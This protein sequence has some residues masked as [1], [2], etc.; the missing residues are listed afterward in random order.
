MI[1]SFLRPWS[2]GPVFS[3]GD[4]GGGGKEDDNAAD[5]FARSARTQDRISTGQAAQAAKN[6]GKSIQELNKYEYTTSEPSPVYQD[7]I[8]RQAAQRDNRSPVFFGGNDDNET[9]T[10]ERRPVPTPTIRPN[11]YGATPP[12]IVGQDYTDT[13][14]Q[15]IAPNATVPYNYRSSAQFGA[16]QYVSEVLGNDS[17][18]YPEVPSYFN[19]DE[20][21]DRNEL[22][23]SA[24]AGDTGIGDRAPRDIGLNDP[25]FG[26]EDLRDPVPPRGILSTLGQAVGTAVGKVD[27]VAQGGI[28]NAYKMADMFNNKVGYV[29]GAGTGLQATPSGLGNQ[30][31][32]A[33][34]SPV[35]TLED[36]GRADKYRED[37][38][39]RSDR[40][41]SVRADKQ[42]NLDT[43]ARLGA[44]PAN[45][46][47]MGVYTTG[48]LAPNWGSS[49][50]DYFGRPTDLGGA[51]LPS[52]IS[53]SAT[54]MAGD[55]NERAQVV[56]NNLPESDKKSL[57]DNV[58]KENG[59]L[60][61]NALWAKVQQAAPSGILALGA[62]LINP[63]LGAAVGAPMYAG[64]AVADRGRMLD[65]ARLSGELQ[66]TPE[67]QEIMNQFGGDNDLALA[68]AKA[69]VNQGSLLS[70]SV[71][72]AAL[73]RLQS[74]Y[75]RAGAAGFAK[76]VG[77][78]GIEEGLL[79][80]LKTYQGAK[81]MFPGESGLNLPTFKQMT[82]EGLT[83]AALAALTGAG[84]GVNTS[85]QG[86]NTNL[87]GPWNK[88]VGP[89]PYNQKGNTTPGTN[90]VSS[91]T[92][93]EVA[94][95]AAANANPVTPLNP[96]NN[97]MGNSD[98]LVQEILNQRA[99]AAQ[100]KAAI[101][102]LLAG[103]Q[104]PAAN[105]FG[106]TNTLENQAIQEIL[107]RRQAAAANEF[108]GTNTLESQAIQEI[109]ARRQAPAANE[110]GGTNSIENQAIQERLAGRQAPAANEFGGTNSI[111]NEILAGRQAPAANEFG[112]TNTLENQAIQEILARRQASAA[113]EFGGTNSIENQQ[114]AENQAAIEALLAGR[115]PP[116]ANEMAGTNT[117]ANQQAEA[118]RQA[119]IARM[120][121]LNDPVANP[122]VNPNNL[123]LDQ[124]V[125]SV[126]D[127]EPARQA[128]IARMMEI[129][130]PALNPYIGPNNQLLDQGVG[131]VQDLES[132]RQAEIAR[133][134]A[135]NDPIS[136][137]VSPNNQ[138]LDQGVGSVAAPSTASSM[139]V[140]AATDI[141]GTELAQTGEVSPNTIQRLMEL[142]GLTRAEITSIIDSQRG[143]SLE[144]YVS[145]GQLF[146][147]ALQLEQNRVD[148]SVTVEGSI[149][150]PPAPYVFDGEVNEY[151]GPTQARTPFSLNPNVNPIEDA[152]YGQEVFET[153][154]PAQGRNTPNNDPIEAQFSDVVAGGTSV[155]SFTRAQ[156]AAIDAQ[157]NAQENISVQPDAAVPEDGGVEDP[158][159]DFT[160]PP[161]PE[162]SGTGSED[163]NVVFPN[164]DDDCPPGYILKLVDGRYICVPIED[165]EPAEVVD[166][167][168][169]K[170][171]GRPTAG[172]YYQ[173]A[174]VGRIDPYIL[175]TTDVV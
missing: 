3:G 72:G 121:E 106:G 136:A 129:N 50:L 162:D 27:D 9:P 91:L 7:S 112:G 131:S 6:S 92:A 114:I 119:E 110:F 94:A 150:R 38:A 124:G 141:I 108:G 109:L 96:L 142:T 49:V 175:N 37:A 95:A 156:Q 69:Q 71:M 128:E 161:F 116:A 144:P 140:M 107:A 113:N 8:I 5:P 164:E 22:L 83:A 23:F 118:A 79:E 137:F 157:I 73:G 135:L 166:S 48:S 163:E 64:E 170:K 169:A 1:N 46:T 104:A 123:P 12:G 52:K 53:Q 103:R 62:G 29:P 90:A 173:P 43:L 138:L 97:P 34:G 55:L 77:I 85:F 105:E 74:K 28:S 93:A 89:I 100:N 70:D 31:F 16:P 168:V 147:P 80:K 153:F 18:Y 19:S 78:E 171:Y 42:L 167:T 67:Y 146:D 44:D 24:A 151:F 152:Q 126:Q 154:G 17:P 45:L 63:A 57:Q 20:Y 125:G 41:A 30:Y 47:D 159:I 101:D 61:P 32:D 56:F 84:A 35:P 111:I 40:L 33:F 172:A 133:M 68:A 88:P 102:A 87:Q 59:W 86:E 36:I 139:G 13:Y 60:D 14:V 21:N 115:Q 122:V 160:I 82:D 120:I 130:N 10:P 117:L 2:K 11:Q 4:E 143:S 54:N 149:N 39:L 148:P 145:Q 158:M 155:P 75:L 51:R 65:E 15:Q 26:T 99:A 98:P 76:N 66:T 132:A 25:M 134:M 81:R 127:L 174:T 58:I 165:E